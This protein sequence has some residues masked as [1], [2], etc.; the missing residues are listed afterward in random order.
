MQKSGSFPT[1]PQTGCGTIS[2]EREWECCRYTVTT[3]YI[4]LKDDFLLTTE[5]SDTIYLLD[6]GHVRLEAHMGSDLDVVNNAK[7]SFAKHSA[8]M[9]EHETGLLNYLMREKHGTPFEAVTFRFNVRCPLF[10]RGEWMRHRIASYNEE[11][12]RYSRV[13]L[14]GFVIEASDVRTQVG[15][16][17]K[18]RFE[19]VNAATAEVARTLIQDSY[20]VAFETYETLLDMGIAREVARTVLP[21]G[22]YTEFYFT[23]NA[24][25]LMNFL[26]LRNADT[27]LREIRYYAQALEDLFGTVMPITHKAFLENGR[28]AP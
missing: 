28:V 7:V 27:A 8:E 24:R 19:P 22:R 14:D 20:N 18:Y 21:E 5:T 10:V 13:R 3:K 25:A 11:S 12:A 26:S 9:G 17:G 4:L 2:L 16:P 1:P 15:K 6:H 23:V